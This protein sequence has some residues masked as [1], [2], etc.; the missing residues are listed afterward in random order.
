L[1]ANIVAMPPSKNIYKK[2]SEA[3]INLEL[4]SVRQGNSICGSAKSDNI[5][6]I[7]IR[8]RLSVLGQPIIG[9]PIFL[10]E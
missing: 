4:R 5:P 3:S 10:Q 2:Y 9:H 6:E 7:T 1:S 8:S